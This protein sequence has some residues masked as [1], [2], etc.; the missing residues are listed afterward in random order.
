MA[1]NRNIHE[2]TAK[3]GNIE[4][5]ET[6]KKNVN[7]RKI[8]IVAVILIIAVFIGFVVIKGTHSAGGFS[9]WIKTDILRMNSGHGYPVD[10]IGNTVEKNNKDLIGNYFAYL[11]DTTFNLLNSS[12]GEMAS[13]QHSLASPSLKCSSSKALVFDVGGNNYSIIDTN[14]NS[15]SSICEG[16]I[17]CADISDSGVYGVAGETNGYLTKLD[18]FNKKNE[19]MYSYK[20]SEYY[21]S[22]LCISPNG[23]RCAVAG[24]STSGGKLVSC[25]YILDFSEEKP[26]NTFKF[27][28]NIIFDIK[29][30]SSDV[31][32]CCGDLESY[33]INLKSGEVL[34]TYSYF[35]K[36][37]SAYA[38]DSKGGILLSLS[39]SADGKECQIVKID[40]NGEICFE[41]STELQITS[42]D[43]NYRTSVAYSKGHI[44]H[45]NDSGEQVAIYECNKDV[46]CVA[47]TSDKTVYTI[48]IS[49]IN[50]IKLQ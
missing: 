34:S 46:R 22:S 42:I 10:L 6:N 14:A 15:F 18:I 26:V 44:Y 11:S 50:Q 39:A 13:V 3:S 29:Y 5:I 28:E 31:I 9:Q 7:K 17:F 8:V 20:M 36:N 38:I 27:D 12:G 30:L 32:A 40:P 19:F 24:V 47:I 41:A 4:I 37:L 45:F 35:G 33:I 23:K 2:Y 48:G 1:N 25:I 49:Q 16:K 43:F 21:A